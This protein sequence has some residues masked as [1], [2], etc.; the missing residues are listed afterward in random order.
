MAQVEESNYHLKNG[1]SVVFRTVLPSDVKTYLAFFKKIPHESTHTLQ[2]V[3]QP[4]RTSSETSERLRSVL[5]ASGALQIGAFLDG[6]MIGFLG[7]RTPASTHPWVKHIGEF[8]MM[9][10]KDYWGLGLGKRL[11]DIMDVHARALGL[12][13]IEANVRT[14]NER[15]VSLYRHHGYT[16]EGTRRNAALINGEYEDEYYIAKI[17]NDSSASWRPPKLDTARLLLRPIEIADAES[18]FEY[19]KNPNVSRYTLWEPHKT[20]DDSLSY[21]RDYV[22]EKYKKS[23]PE[24]FGIALKESPEKLIGTVGCF[25]V[26][27]SARSMELAYAIAEEHWGKG[28]VPEAASAV[29]DYCFK[30]YSLKRLQARCKN[31]NKASRRVMEKVG[32]TYEGTLKSAVFHRDRYWDMDYFARVSVSPDY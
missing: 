14:T 32:M 1:H 16:V 6:Q 29:M 26:S 9:I 2:Y 24:P 19:A 11:L 4:E 27:R 5:G 10:L 7:F 13:R 3:G 30:E 31:E 28:L 20:V 18:I 12:T 25:W 8:G 21:I 17:L 22:F 15:G 23:V